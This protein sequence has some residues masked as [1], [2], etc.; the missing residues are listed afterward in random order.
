MLFDPRTALV[1]KMFCHPLT[2]LMACARANPCFVG[3]H[4]DRSGAIEEL[5][6]LVVLEAREQRRKKKLE[7]RKFSESAA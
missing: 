6:G 1:S 4:A 2:S 3:G 7:Q 5:E